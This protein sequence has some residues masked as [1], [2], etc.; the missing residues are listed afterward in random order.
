M[1]DDKRVICASSALKDGATGVRFKVKTAAGEVAAFAVRYDGKIYA[2]VNRCA[3]VPVELDW[4]DGAFFD[5]SKLYLICST[6]GAMYLP[7]T[8]VC[9]QGPCRGKS[10]QAVAIEEHDGQVFLMKEFKNV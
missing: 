1:A 8:G 4:M 3:H 2:Y 5:Y 6:H 7:H 9:V 10:L